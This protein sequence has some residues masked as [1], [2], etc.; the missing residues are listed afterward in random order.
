MS[1]TEQGMKSTANVGRNKPRDENNSR[2]RWLS[3]TAAVKGLALL[4]SAGV[5]GEAGALMLSFDYSYT[6]EAHTCS[7]DSMV[8]GVPTPVSL[9]G[10]TVMSAPIA[11]NWDVVTKAQLT[12]PS[13]SKKTFG[14]LMTCTGDIYLPELK[15]TGINKSNSDGKI[16]AAGVGAV[17]G[18]QIERAAD[19]D[20]PGGTEL[21]TSS[22][23][24]L[25]E[26]SSGQRKILLTAWPVIMPGKNADDLP[27]GDNAITGTVTINVSYN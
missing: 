16:Y 3:R 12:G 5:C 25:G 14:L 13:H 19:S 8:D 22:P 18:F 26:N 24:L 9:S 20:I 2:R 4:L 7:L 10:N 21:N 15:I 23:I 6:I 1:R 27:S 11:V 17:A